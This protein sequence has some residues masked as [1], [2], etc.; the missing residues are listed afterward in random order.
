MSDGMITIFVN[1]G[2]YVDKA[3]YIQQRDEASRLR[4]RCMGYEAKV[5]KLQAVVDAARDFVNNHMD[6]DDAMRI[7]DAL[8]ALENDDE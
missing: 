4:E 2:E 1:G 3:A 7:F 8:A 5:A 6:H